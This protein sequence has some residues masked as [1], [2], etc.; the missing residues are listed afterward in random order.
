M[1]LKWKDVHTPLVL[2]FVKGHE[3]LRNTKS[4]HCR[5]NTASKNALRETLHERN[6]PELN[7]E[8]VKLKIKQSVSGMLLS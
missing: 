2:D 7:V 1:G 6:F 5:S 3:C 4:E 8:D